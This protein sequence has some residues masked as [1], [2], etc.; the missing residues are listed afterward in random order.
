MLTR[1]VL[2]V[3]AI[4][5]PVL[6]WKAIETWRLNRRIALH[7]QQIEEAI[8]GADEIVIEATEA[9]KK[10]L[11][12]ECEEAGVEVPDPVE[13]VLTG[14]DEVQAL[15]DSFEFRPTWGYVCACLGDTEI[16][17]YEGDRL[18]LSLVEH[19]A[20][21]IGWSS[22]A[23]G[24]I[25]DFSELGKALFREWLRDKYLRVNPWFDYDWSPNKDGADATGNGTLSAP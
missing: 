14:K 21:R 13:V 22:G 19:H 10:Y 20:S 11:H 7:R 15:L 5:T 24:A 16:K 12:E 23:S 18:R 2:V 9:R 3:L 1:V 4:V 17:V 8:R 25:D 6:T